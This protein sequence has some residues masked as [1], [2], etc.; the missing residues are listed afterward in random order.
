MVYN[1]WYN[2]DRRNYLRNQVGSMHSIVKSAKSLGLYL[3]PTLRYSHKE[4]CLYY[5][6][7]GICNAHFWRT[8]Y[9]HPYPSAGDQTLMGW[10]SNDIPIHRGKGGGD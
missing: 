1:T 10:A 6:I 4:E 9:R 2:K 8:R 3:P 7:G 5:H